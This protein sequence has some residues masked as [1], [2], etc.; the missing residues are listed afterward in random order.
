MNISAQIVLSNDNVFHR[1]RR[2]SRV[3]PRW[4]GNEN[5]SPGLG[6]VWL[7]IEASVAGYFHVGRAVSD[8]N[9]GPTLRSISIG[10]I[11]TRIRDHIARDLGSD[12]VV[13]YAY[14]AQP[15]VPDDVV[16]HGEA[17]TTHLNAACS[18]GAAIHNRVP[19]YNTNGIRRECISD[20][21]LP[22]ARI[23]LAAY[24]VIRNRYLAP[25][26]VNPSTLDDV[27]VDHDRRIGIG[28]PR[29]VPNTHRRLRSWAS[30]DAICNSTT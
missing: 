6:F 22:S 27:V 16:C 12:H 13:T 25:G 21:D 23:R 8:V 14:T 28:S 15:M 9:S 7:V 30:D 20:I 18:E 3:R 10:H 11:M 17:A 5:H 1:F 24:L 26:T 29:V 19:A 2:E 4:W